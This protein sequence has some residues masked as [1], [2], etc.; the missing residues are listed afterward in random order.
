MNIIIYTS[1]SGVGFLMFCT[2]A[3]KLNSFGREESLKLLI[4]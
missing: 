3:Y 4:V 2:I 1:K